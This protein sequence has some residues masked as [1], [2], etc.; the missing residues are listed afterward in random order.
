[1]R[2][3]RCWRAEKWW[4]GD[5]VGRHVQD[6]A[7]PADAVRVPIDLSGYA[8]GVYMLRVRAASGAGKVLPLVVLRR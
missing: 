6:L 4:C 8:A 2:S 3:G 7:L 5:E 1:M